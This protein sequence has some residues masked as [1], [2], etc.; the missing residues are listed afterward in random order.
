MQDFSLLIAVGTQ[1]LP[2][3]IAE[4]PFIAVSVFVGHYS[5]T[6]L[7][8]LEPA[9]EG[10]A[11]AVSILP[12]QLLVIHPLSPKIIS[13]RVAIDAKALPFAVC[14]LSLVVLIIQKFY[15]SLSQHQIFLELSNILC[16]IFPLVNALS[17]FLGELEV[18]LIVVPVIVKHFSPA[19][20]VI[21]SPKPFDFGG[22]GKDDGSDS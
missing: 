1:T 4:L 12:N 5:A 8:L 6:D 14:Y 20:D 13:V 3:C 16:V 17:L 15:L 19:F 7:I 2:L 10:S 22:V 21:V 18:A 11:I 9:I